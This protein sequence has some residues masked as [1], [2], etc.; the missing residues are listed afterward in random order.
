MTPCSLDHHFLWVGRC[1]VVGWSTHEMAPLVVTKRHCWI[2]KRSQ[3][4]I[5]WVSC[6]IVRSCTGEW[7]VNSL[8]FDQ[9]RGRII[10]LQEAH[11]T[12]ERERETDWL[13]W[14][15]DCELDLFLPTF[16]LPKKFFKRP[17]D[18][19]LPRL[20]TAT[21]HLPKGVSICSATFISKLL[22]PEHF[23]DSWMVWLLIPTMGEVVLSWLFVCC[24]CISNLL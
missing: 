4:R 7:K 17:G 20:I 3:N 13:D 9:G 21:G 1:A 23:F 16:L 8:M 24:L 15:R 5:S 22:G 14:L 11:G 2:E 10:Y 6:V 18:H 12:G 19:R